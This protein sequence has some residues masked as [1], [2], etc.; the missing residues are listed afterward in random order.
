MHK[1]VLLFPILLICCSKAPDD[2]R[3]QYFPKIEEKPEVIPDKN[4][5]WAF[6]LAGQSNMAGRAK[7]EPVDTLP[8]AGVLALNTNGELV[9]A[10]EPLHRYEPAIAGLGSGLSFGKELLKHIPDSVAVLLIPTAVGGS[11]IEQWINDSTHRSVPLLTNF[12]QKTEIAKEY[13]TIKGVLWHQGESDAREPEKIASYDRHL[14][15]LFNYFREVANDPGLPILIGELGSFSETDEAWQSINS[16][17]REYL[18]ADPNSFAVQT[19]DLDHKGDRI[20]F[21]S[22]GQRELG[23]RFAEKFIEIEQSTSRNGVGK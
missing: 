22:E 20:H 7:V 8:N 6:L 18:E 12:K 17:I 13:G 9:I 19:H 16:K 5:V 23:K 14:Q 15:T 21:N 10:K 1:L 2:D 11:A 3:T 4:N